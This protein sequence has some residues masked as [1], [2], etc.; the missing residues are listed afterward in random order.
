MNYSPVKLASCIKGYLWGGRRLITD[1]NKKTE[2]E[3]AAESWELSTHKDGESVVASGEFKGLKLTE[4]IAKNGGNECIG[5][6]ASEFD[7]F[8]V[9]IKL[10]DAKDNLSIQ[11]HPDDEYALRVE[12]EYGKTEMWYIVDCE[13]GSYLY[14]GVNHKITKEEFERRIS[15]KTLLEVLNKVPV[16][17]GDVFFIPAGTIHAICSGILI[18]EIQQNSNTTY[19]IY[20]YDRR[21]KDGNPRELHVEKAQAVSR[22]TPSPEQKKYEGN[23]LADCKYFTVEKIDCN[24]EK[25]VTLTDESFRSLVVLSGSGTFELGGETIDFTKG[26][27]IFIPAQNANAVLK[28]NFE[29]VLSY[30]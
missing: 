28:G 4:Y 6:K 27:S 19:R 26:D 30:V 8:P 12:G 29:A 21:D 24:G 18:C 7:F 3:K 1:F 14:Y 13:E 2:L 9:L 11:V 5:S 10:I 16:K 17:K 23:V 15:D 22:L 25:K 20:D